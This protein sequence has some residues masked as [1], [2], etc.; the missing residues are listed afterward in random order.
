L[1]CSKPELDRLAG[2]YCGDD[3][4]NPLASPLKGD[5]SGLAPLLIHV[6][7]DEILLSDA[8]RLSERA[9]LSRVPVRLMIAPHMPHVWH[10]FTTE[11]TAAQTAIAHAGAWMREHLG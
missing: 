2:L 6:G 5:L 9:G 7:S 11:L 10:F 8:L 4:A 3:R 1:I